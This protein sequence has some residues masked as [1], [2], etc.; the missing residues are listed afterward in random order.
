MINIVK[1]GIGWTY[2]GSFHRWSKTGAPTYGVV[3]EALT[4]DYANGLAI[5]LR[6]LF[7]EVQLEPI[8]DGPAYRITAT[9][10]RDINAS[11]DDPTE[12]I[13]DTH[14]LDGSVY[15]QPLLGSPALQSH[16]DDPEGVIS[17]VSQLANDIKKHSK[18]REEVILLL[19]AIPGSDAQ[20][21]A[22][23]TDLLDMLVAGNDSYVDTRYVYKQTFNV[24]D[25][26]PFTLNYNNINCVFST[27]AD[28]LRL[29]N[30]ELPA[31]FTLPEGQWLKITPKQ[32]KQYGSSI[33]FLYEYW[34]ATEWSALLYFEAA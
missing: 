30:I 1:K 9:T 27:T 29:E 4:L 34:W 21:I 31:N 5:D 6:R 26:V 24:P 20:E 19:A 23:A 28:L 32:I 16:F 13:I 10:T 33:Q 12:Q 25:D 2:K 17:L 3:Y 7:T 11:P 18:T 14:E 15:Q 22:D 8:S